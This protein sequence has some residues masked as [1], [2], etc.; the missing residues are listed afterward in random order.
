MATIEEVDFRPARG[1]R[2]AVAI[3]LPFV[4]LIGVASVQSGQAASPDP[5]SRVQDSGVEWTGLTGL[6]G[7]MPPGSA[8]DAPWGA[9]LS[10]TTFLF[11]ER[12]PL[13]SGDDEGEVTHDALTEEQ[14]GR[15]QAAIDEN[16][17]RLDVEG[18]LPPPGALAV[19]FQWPLRASPQLSDYGYH[20]IWD[21]VDHDPSYP[22][23]LLD[24]N[25]GNRS[26]DWSSG[27]NHQGTDFGLWPF[28]WNKMDGD[29]VQVVAVAP[30]TIVGKD[31]GNF[32]RN[33]STDPGVTWNAVYIRHSDG[34]VAWYGHLKNGSLTPKTVG[35]S[36][37]AG[38]YLGIVGSS[39]QSTE[40]HLHFEVYNAANGLIDPYFGPCN[41]LTGE[42]WWASQRP[43]YDSGIN[44][45][46]T[47]TAP[48]ENQPCPNPAITHQADHFNPGDTVYYTAFYR[49]LVN[50]QVSHYTIYRPDGSIF[51]SW[52]F[53][54]TNAGFSPA[55]SKWWSYGLSPDAMQGT[56]RFEVIYG[57]QTYQAT[58]I[59]GDLLPTYLPLILRD[60]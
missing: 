59:V 49:D 11:P 1:P 54:F 29:Q 34:S 18:K 16:I 26:Y 53:T 43:Y 8:A 51:Q 5:P 23:Q 42:S 48:A 9:V 30:G 50:G 24:Y 15:I 44:R 56:W 4:F 19:P 58:F 21:F 25:C 35:N 57:G 17:W 7:D 31:D 37:E 3:L 45:L 52:D 32:D 14:R 38:E 27:Y 20:V 6:P 46:M 39:G 28:P 2:A 10:D 22:N 36:V 33:C 55:R 60:Q 41:S 13:A 47:G 12:L 40:P